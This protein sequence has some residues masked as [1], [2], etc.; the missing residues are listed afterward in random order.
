MDAS[1]PRLSRRRAR[2]RR[3][4]SVLAR[5]VLHF[6]SARFD[7]DN[8]GGTGQAPNRQ[9]GIGPVA[10]EALLSRDAGELVVQ[11]IAFGGELFGELNAALMASRGAEPSLLELGE[12]TLDGAGGAAEALTKGLQNWVTGGAQPALD[13]EALEGVPCR[14]E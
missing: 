12:A 8:V 6:R 13:L 9:E 5:L 11:G 7:V 10:V 3:S 2:H 14:A 1:D 4:L